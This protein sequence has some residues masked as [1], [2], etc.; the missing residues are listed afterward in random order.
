LE[1][2][3][4]NSNN[5]KRINK[6]LKY[7]AL[8]SQLELYNLIPTP[9]LRELD[10]VI[11]LMSIAL[12]ISDNCKWIDDYIRTRTERDYLGY[13]SKKYVILTP[14]S[15]HDI[16][17]E[18]FSKHYDL[19]N[20]IDSYANGTDRI[21]FLRRIDSM[22][23]PFVSVILSNSID[24]DCII[25]PHNQLPDISVFEFLKQYSKAM[26]LRFDPSEIIDGLFESDYYLNGYTDWQLESLRA[27][28]DINR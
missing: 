26:C 16:Y 28:A 9:P 18:A 8:C 13:W 14:T 25:G 15:L 2:L 11:E 10:R 6:Y 20:F 7:R 22:Q 24:L 5:I 1:H 21:L 3:D 19:M 4:V 27:Y 23:E 17:I 12:R